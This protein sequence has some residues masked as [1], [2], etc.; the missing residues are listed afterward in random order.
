MLSRRRVQGEGKLA[1][2]RL[3]NV[4]GRISDNQANKT[5]A[6]K[7][8]AVPTMHIA[9]VKTGGGN[10]HD[11]CPNRRV[12]GEGSHVVRVG[13]GLPAPA[14]AEIDGPK[15]PEQDR[16]PSHSA[17]HSELLNPRVRTDAHK[18]AVDDAAIDHRDRKHD[19]HK[20]AV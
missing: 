12:N 14:R 19:A 6:E 17:A 8:D 11:A 5:C 7:G 1:L 16:E 3:L 15:A 20:D 13:N 9:F 10:L 4:E 18:G 2:L